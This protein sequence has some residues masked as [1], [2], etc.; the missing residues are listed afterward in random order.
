MVIR[1]RRKLPPFR[2]VPIDLRRRR[3]VAP[4]Y[5]NWYGSY[6]T[7]DGRVKRFSF[8]AKVDPNKNPMVL[9]KLIRHICNKI[10]KGQIPAVPNGAI[11]DDFGDLIIATP[12]IRVR[13]IRFYKAG[14]EYER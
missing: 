6:V 11:L 14:M 4:N 5:A 13:K 12:W 2:P 1:N 9:Y 8:K 10:K 7:K 3:R